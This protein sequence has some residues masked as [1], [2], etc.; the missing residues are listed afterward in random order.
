MDAPY[1]YV[2]K[3][4]ISPQGAPEI[5]H[6]LDSKHSA[7][8]VAQPGFAFVRRV[9]L[10]E[11]AS[12]GWHAY[13]MIYGLESRDALMRY[14]ESDAPRRYAEERKPFEQHLRTERAWGEIDFK[15][16]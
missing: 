11:T 8:V 2:V 10:E 15:I 6:W 9:K 5:L 13:M 12:D 3:F 4:W 14:F 7:D 16:G 1:F